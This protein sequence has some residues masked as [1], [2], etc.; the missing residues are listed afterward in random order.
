MPSRPARL[1]EPPGRFGVLTGG[2]R[3]VRQLQVSRIRLQISMDLLDSFRF[4]A[5]SAH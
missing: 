2:D 1:P 4:E 5:D 3:L